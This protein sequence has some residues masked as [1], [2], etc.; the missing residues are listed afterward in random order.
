MDFST[1]EL[2]F[3]QHVFTSE[4][5]NNKTITNEHNLTVATSIPK[6]VA[7][8]LGNAKLTLLAQ[9]SHYQLWFPLT[10]KKNQ[11]N[12]FTP[13][14]GT[15]EIMDMQGIDRSWRVSSPKNVS[16]HNKGTKQ[17]VE[18]LSL[19]SSG[20]TMRAKCITS[21]NKLFEGKELEMHLPDQRQVKLALESVR[22][23]N[24]I[25]TGRFKNVA[26]GRDCLRKFLFNL[27]R[28]EYSEL[29]EQIN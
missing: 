18:I 16:L 5:E 4:T 28:T 13:I 21:A 3:F 6:N 23:E 26:Q 15:P 1:E 8:I 25:I 14:L 2:D 7:D 19:S 22:S 29:Y 11:D 20:I 27:H 12:E 24:N 10:I 17:Q 9:I